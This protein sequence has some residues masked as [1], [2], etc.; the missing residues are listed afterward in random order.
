MDSFARYCLVEGI[1]QLGYLQQHMDKIEA[2]EEHRS[3][4]P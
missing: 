1:D 2:F 4:T 3:W